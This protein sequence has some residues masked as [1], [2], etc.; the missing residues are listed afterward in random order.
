MVK[1]ISR[2]PSQILKCPPLP[3]VTLGQVRS[4]FYQPSPMGLSKVHHLSITLLGSAL[5]VI[6]IR[7]SVLFLF[8]GGWVWKV[9]HGYQICHRLQNWK[10]L[11]SI[12]TT[13]SDLRRRDQHCRKQLFFHIITFSWHASFNASNAKLKVPSSIPK[14]DRKKLRKFFS[15]LQFHDLKCRRR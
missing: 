14:W 4:S 3:S 2:L 9:S 1:I 6:F 8:T 7:L 13:E 5:I 12:Q 11:S 15:L 10:Q